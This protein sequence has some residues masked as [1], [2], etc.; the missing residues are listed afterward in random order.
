MEE[1]G[2]EDEG[3]SDDAAGGN[4]VC[5]V[6]GEEEANDD[7]V[8]EER[9]P[10]LLRSPGT[11]SRREVEEHELTHIPFRP[12][13]PS[14]VCGRGIN[15]PHKKIQR[16]EEREVPL[17]AADYGHLTS[18]ADPEKPHFLVMRDRESGAEYATVVPHKGPGDEWLPKACARWIDGL[19]YNKVILRTDQE[20]SI[21]AWANEVRRHRKADTIL[22]ASPV[23]EKQANG[24]AESAVREIKG[25]VRTIVHSIEAKTGEEVNPRDAIMTWI[26]KHAAVVRTR[27]KVG[28]D[29]K[30]PYERIKGKKSSRPLVHIGEKVM[31]MPLKPGRLGGMHSRFFYG[32]FLGINERTDEVC[33]GTEGG[34]IKAQTMR[35]L[36]EEQRW[37]MKAIKAV[38]GTPWA[39]IDGTSPVD[40]GTKIN[41]DMPREEVPDPMN[42]EPQYR[43]MHITKADLHTYGFTPGCAGCRAVQEGAPRSMTHHEKCRARIQEALRRD[44]EGAARLD[45]EVERLTEAAARKIEENERRAAEKQKAEEKARGSAGASSSSGSQ[46]TA[47]EKEGDGDKRAVHSSNSE[48]QDKEENETNKRSDEKDDGVDSVK[49]RRKE[50]SD[51]GKKRDHDT[52]DD[53]RIDGAKKRKVENDDDDIGEMGDRSDARTGIL[54]LTKHT[55]SGKERD[56]SSATQRRRV[57][58]WMKDRSIGMVVADTPVWACKALR[59]NSDNEQIAKAMVH[60]NF[61]AQIYREAMD[62]AIKFVHLHAG[63]S[64]AWRMPCIMYMTAMLGAMSGAMRVDS[65][66]GKSRS[67]LKIL[68]NS[69]MV[70]DTM[71]NNRVTY[72]ACDPKD[73]IKSKKSCMAKIVTMVH[74]SFI[75]EKLKANARR[76][77]SMDKEVE[78]AI[79]YMES[80]AAERKAEIAA[81]EGKNAMEVNALLHHGK[82]A[83]DDVKGGELMADKVWSARMEEMK[84]FRSRKVYDK[85]GLEECWQRT[86]KGPI[87]TKWVETNKGTISEP[88]YRSRLVGKEFKRDNN[89]D[90]FAAMPPLDAVKALLSKAASQNQT[91]GIMFADIRRAYFYAPV[92]RDLYIQI[93]EEDWEPGDEFRCA[94]LRVSL[95]GTR[96]A[97]HN[98]DTEMGKFMDGCKFVRGKASPCVYA[99]ASDNADAVIHGDDICC[100]GPLCYLEKLKDMIMK[101]YEAKTSIMGPGAYDK[102]AKMLNRS[103]KWTE[104]GIEIEADTRHAAEIIKGA[105]M[106][107]AKGVSTPCIPDDGESEK[108]IRAIDYKKIEEKCF[109]GEQHQRRGKEEDHWRKDGEGYVTRVHVMQRKSLCTPMGFRGSPER[110]EHMIGLRITEGKWTEN[111]EPFSIIDNWKEAKDPNKDMSGRWT[112]TTTF[113]V[114][115]QEEVEEDRLE[116]HEATKYRALAARLIYLSQDRPDLKYVSKLCSQCMAVP[117]VKAWRLMKRVA[118]YIKKYPRAVCV[119]KWGHSESAKLWIASDSDWA[120]DRRTRKSTSGGAVWLGAHFLKGWSRTQSCITLSSAEAELCAAVRA[121]VEGMGC[122]SVLRDM[123]CNVTIELGMDASAAIAMINR[124][125][126]GRAR[127]IGTQFM[128]MQEAVREGKVRIV[129][130]ASKNNPADLFTKPLPEES[131]QR[132]MRTMGYEYR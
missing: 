131:I 47:T 122:Q 130:L 84:Y 15:S 18:K 16:K 36:G 45:K 61:C 125:G 67:Y 64:R 81:K 117:T 62:N 10:K 87:G 126:L 78:E 53:D 46:E 33:I 114:A 109:G 90:F 37:D 74:D 124:E 30:T 129:K 110:K 112:G 93:P 75:K 32:V 73:K 2:D 106:E 72:D 3:K 1:N 88:N 123:R 24:V 60:M 119:F 91:V 7:E 79:A 55:S 22:E 56:F 89:P 120:G 31:Y 50:E 8:E 82:Y 111:G 38:R 85:V 77:K 26:V 68:S 35:R 41:E 17:I 71:S 101:K 96:D 116:D 51:I 92:Q 6:C 49:R 58:S 107:A 20:V 80:V 11:P 27:F 97:A 44:R 128:W 113:K 4:E 48:G 14:C 25:M 34:V 95:Y 28:Q 98:W 12:W 127:H 19:G 29:G 108:D 104:V 132:H 66:V 102:E 105:G 115:A 121:L 99:N 86:G 69:R 5:G 118:R 70:V 54:D 23:S 59:E 21:E 52:E 39:P 9:K 76:L 57:R 43:R 94:K 63:S 13:C 103:I 83:V 40:I 42:F 100:V 65:S